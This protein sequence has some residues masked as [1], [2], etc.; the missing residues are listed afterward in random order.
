M[1][2]LMPGQSRPTAS[3]PPVPALRHKSIGR[4][5]SWQ[6]LPDHFQCLTVCP[7]AGFQG[8]RSAFIW[9]RYAR[10]PFIVSSGVA[11]TGS[12]RR[13][14]DVMRPAAIRCS[15][16]AHKAPEILNLAKLIADP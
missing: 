12:K 1:P 11:E 10:L 15:H 6:P 3:G 9:G 5:G 13:V 2:A 16:T 14:S 7:L 8:M 4:I